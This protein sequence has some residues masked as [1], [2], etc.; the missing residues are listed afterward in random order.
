MTARVV[1][2]A[3]AR[4]RF[5]TEDLHEAIRE[6]HA[7]GASLRAIAKAADLSHSTVAEIV[8]TKPKRK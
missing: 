5:D 2:K 8:N 3:A 4:I 1:S 7:E 6:M